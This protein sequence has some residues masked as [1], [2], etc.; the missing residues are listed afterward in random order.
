VK[1]KERLSYA[2]HRVVCSCEDILRIS[3]SVK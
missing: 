2:T 1:K 3:Y